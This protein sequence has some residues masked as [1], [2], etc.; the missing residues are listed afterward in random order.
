MA[1]K[2]FSQWDI[3]PEKVRRAF[4]VIGEWENRREDGG[5][6]FML[7][8]D[9]DGKLREE[10]GEEIYIQREVIQ[11]IVGLQT[12]GSVSEIKEAQGILQMAALVL[13]W[14]H[15][16]PSERWDPDAPG[17]AAKK[18]LEEVIRLNH[19]QIM[20]KNHE[21]VLDQ[22]GLKYDPELEMAVSKGGRG[23]PSPFINRIA[24]TQAILLKAVYPSL[25]E[26]QKEIHRRLSRF[27][28]IPDDDAGLRNAIE[29]ATRG[30]PKRPNP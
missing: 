22:N 23:R 17:E 8:L 27:F 6:L 25:K 19:V 11:A 29:N 9:P 12:Y 1:K 26:L 10:Y 20:A 18:V 13:N 7:Y 16:Q 2:K 15:Q 30:V 28:S 5:D 24:G 14:I 3:D 21:H 4:A